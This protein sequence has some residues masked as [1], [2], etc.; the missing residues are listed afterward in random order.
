MAWLLQ[1]IREI[2]Q[3]KPLVYKCLQTT[4]KHMLPPSRPDNWQDAI[5]ALPG[6]KLTEFVQMVQRALEL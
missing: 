3:N 2:K 1:S 4:L 5:D 6:Y